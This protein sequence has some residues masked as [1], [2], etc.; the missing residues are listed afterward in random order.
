MEIFVRPSSTGSCI[1]ISAAVAKA[2]RAANWADNV[3]AATYL[4]RALLV[5]RA[6]RR[7]RWCI[8]C[9][10]GQHECAMHGLFA[11][12]LVPRGKTSLHG[13]K[14]PRCHGHGKSPRQQ[15]S[16]ILVVRRCEH[17]CTARPWQVSTSRRPRGRH[18]YAWGGR[19]WRSW[20]TSAARASSSRPSILS[21]TRP[22]VTNSLST[23]SLLP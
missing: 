21:S 6:E 11:H 16:R 9:H 5:Q 8:L 19:I 18:G 14:H 10:P 15:S 12:C 2:I 3:A 20:F 7:H 13:S 4:L 17:H 1:R 22:L 23:P